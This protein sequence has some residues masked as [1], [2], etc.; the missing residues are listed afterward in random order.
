MCQIN[1][2]SQNMKTRSQYTYRVT[3]TNTVYSSSYCGA[4]SAI[5][6]VKYT[7]HYG[8]IQYQKETLLKIPKLDKNSEFEKFGQN[9]TMM[10][11]DE[12]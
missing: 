1:T 11:F 7:V 4:H 9:G 10:T 8:R 3:Q 12:I 6:T 5:I 2:K